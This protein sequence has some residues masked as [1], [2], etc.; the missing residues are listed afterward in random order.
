M[1]TDMLG[2]SGPAQRD[3]ARALRVPWRVSRGP[4]LYRAEAT[5]IG[6]S[7]TIDPITLN[8]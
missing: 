5:W 6:S 2:C 4:A 8:P 1:F 3:E 7:I